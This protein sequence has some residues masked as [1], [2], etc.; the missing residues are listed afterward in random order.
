MHCI[1]R[2]V[3]FCWVAGVTALALLA[4]GCGGFDKAWRASVGA[5][6]AQEPLLGRWKGIWKSEPSGHTDE[7][8]CLITP[9]TNGAYQA[10]FHAR[11]G[12]FPRFSFG[13]T[14]ALE[15]DEV[16]PTMRFHGGADLG[17]LAGGMYH[18]TGVATGTNLRATY[19]SKSDHGTFEMS[20]PVDK[21]TN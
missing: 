9:G 11:Y 19:E 13:Y 6:N 3:P 8:R 4:G 12:K 17:W 16:G 14:L 2:V 7:L 1:H 5:E 10:R 20:R 21:K 18:C 15:A